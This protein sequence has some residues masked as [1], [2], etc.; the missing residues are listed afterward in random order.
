MSYVPG[1][2]TGVS[3]LIAPLYRFN[4]LASIETDALGG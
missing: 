2:L 4:A 3:D 1:R